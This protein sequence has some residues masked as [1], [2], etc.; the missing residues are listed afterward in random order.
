M[1]KT[2]RSTKDS[3]AA[4]GINGQKLASFSPHKTTINA[5]S[6]QMASGDPSAVSAG[7]FSF[8]VLAKLLSS[9]IVTPIQTFV[10]TPQFN[11]GVTVIAGIAMY[12]ASVDDKVNDG[13][14]TNNIKPLKVSRYQVLDLNDL[15]PE[16]V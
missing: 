2:L 8:N 6:T 7:G 14:E 4:F 10:A 5:A 12:L 1:N 11:L 13:L 16:S 9:N 3:F 15:I